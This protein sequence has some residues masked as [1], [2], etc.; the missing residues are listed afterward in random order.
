MKGYKNAFSLSE[1]VTDFTEW[2]IQLENIFSKPPSKKSAEQRQ[3]EQ[4]TD[5][6]QSLLAEMEDTLKLIPRKGNNPA[7]CQRTTISNQLGGL[8]HCINAIQ[9]EDFT[10][11]EYS[12]DFKFSYS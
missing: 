9:L 10:P 11:N 1:S 8:D 4:V 2:K 3:F 7:T 12:A 5:K 6:F